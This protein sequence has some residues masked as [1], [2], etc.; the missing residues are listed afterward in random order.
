MPRCWILFTVLVFTPLLS[1]ADWLQ[2]RGSTHNS[3]A[4]TRPPT[5]FSIQDQKNVAWQVDLPGRGPASPIVVKNRVIVTA[6]DGARQEK[7][8]VLCFDADSGKELWRRQFWATGRTLTHKES[9]V[10]APTPASDG[11][12]IFAFYSSNDLAC[13]DLDGNLLWYRG[14]A[15]DYP[16]AGNDIGMASSP[17]VIDG[18]VVVQVEN[19][20]DSFAAGLDAATG[21]ERWRVAR[22]PSA[23]WSS[24]ISFPAKDGAQAILQD[25]EK[26]VGL[27]ART[28]REVWNFKLACNGTASSVLADGK[29]YVPADGITALDLGGHPTAPELLWDSNKLAA[30]GASAVAYKGQVY[31]VN[32]AG[33]LTCADAKTGEVTSQLRLK[34]PVWAT[35]VIAGDHLYLMSYEGLAHVVNLAGDKP[36]LVGTAE[37]GE[38]IQGTPAIANGALFVR[39]DAHLWKIAE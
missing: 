5:T 25:G 18:T 28:G 24:P 12:R 11:E 31:T 16:K 27:D 8:Y 9:A 22:S 38:K 21:Q 34:G 33:V 17:V 6:S 29:L 20:G 2:F 19:Q 37:F 3:V 35:P 26:L 1:G 30:S 13:L 14:L 10:A 39:S 7:L 36:E 23:N 15:Y 32:R 4:E